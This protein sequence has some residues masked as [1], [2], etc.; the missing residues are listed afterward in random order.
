VK[1]EYPGRNYKAAVWRSRHAEDPSAAPVDDPDNPGK[2]IQPKTCLRHEDVRAIEEA[3]GDPD[4]LCRDGKRVCPLTAT[5]AYLQMREQVA[6]ASVIFA[7]HEMMMHEMP[8][9]FGNV[10][11][12]MIDE[13]SV[14]APTFGLGDERIDL[15]LDAL[16]N[17]PSSQLARH[18]ARFL[19]NEHADL[20]R[21]LD[22]IEFPDFKKGE[23]EIQFE[24]V[25]ARVLRI[26]ASWR[27]AT[28]NGKLERSGKVT[29][30]FDPTMSRRQLLA[31]LKPSADNAIIAKMVRFWEAI[32]GLMRRYPPVTFKT[33]KGKWQ[34]TPPEID[35][36]L[37]AR[38]KFYRTKKEGRFL[39]VIGRQPLAADWRNLPTL[40]GDANGDAELL[41]S[42]WPQLQASE[43]PQPQLP[44]NVR[45]IQVPGIN[46]TMK[47]I[48]PR[49]PIEY[50]LKQ[51]RKAARQ[52]YA[53]VLATALRYGGAPCV[54]ITYKVTE[55][56]IRETCH[57]PP[58]LALGHFGAATGSNLHVGVRALFELGRLLVPA[59]A[60]AEMIEA[61][62]GEYISDRHY[63]PTGDGWRHRHP[64]VERWRWTICEGG[65][66]QAEGRARAP[67]RGSKGG[68][69]DIWR[70]HREALPGAT[71][72]GAL[73]GGLDAQMLAM[74][75]RAFENMYHAARFYPGLLTVEALQKDRERGRSPTFPYEGYPSKGMSDSSGT[76][77]EHPALLVTVRYQLSGPGNKETGAV[78]LRDAA[79]PRERREELEGWRGELEDKL[80][81]LAYFEVIEG[82]N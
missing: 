11:L 32:D 52:A 60:A 20:Y 23:P 67:W 79:S 16:R 74:G 72:R 66:L 54:L 18:H 1:R 9:Q 58:W 56:Y 2:K 51:Q 82:G 17:P 59:W 15:P 3:G 19:R 7:A 36:A 43:W 42:I 61:L 13:N 47:A 29:P 37:A 75:G 76:K 41:K 49:S 53:A 77:R 80:G 78:F 64:L 27:T 35:D 21:A 12:L 68:P 70:V 69:L 65:L 39:R 8:K 31:A 73:V 33:V 48:A 62:T 14:D 81:A 57:I 45:I 5:C 10:G 6:E 44:P 30:K 34:F 26:F 55:E 46:T 22:Q 28:Y 63:V 40:I 24:P 50:K 38:I 4:R 71:E 25:P